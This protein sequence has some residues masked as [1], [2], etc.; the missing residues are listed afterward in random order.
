MTLAGVCVCTGEVSC[1]TEGTNKPPEGEGLNQEA[2]ITLLE[3]Y[4]VS[5]H[6][7]T[8][9][10]SWDIDLFCQCFAMSTLVGSPL[11]RGLRVYMLRAPQKD[12][13]SGQHITE[14]PGVIKWEKKLRKTCASMG[15]RFVSYKPAGG[16]WKFEVREHSDPLPV[17][18]T[19]QC[20]LSKTR[21]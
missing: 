3:V 11:Y 9:T 1:Y 17:Q 18:P 12:K 16:V 7:H 8:C 13:E 2:L 14:G 5:T 10:H 19:Y 15:A 21:H 20:T 6:T 4:L